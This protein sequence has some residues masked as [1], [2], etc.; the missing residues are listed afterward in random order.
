MRHLRDLGFGTTA[1][2]D[3]I[4]DEI[5]EMLKEIKETAAS[6]PAGIVD[7]KGVFNV[8]VINI[9]WAIA[10][11]QRFRR[12]DQDFKQILRTLD[13]I[14]RSGDQIRSIVPVPRFL[15]RMFPVLRQIFGTRNDLFEQLKTFFEV[16]LVLAHFKPLIM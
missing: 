7:Y 12:D 5:R 8:S 2:E 11:G 3:M 13:V 16:T 4:S 10:G 6:N 1:I 15:L 9:L 14:F